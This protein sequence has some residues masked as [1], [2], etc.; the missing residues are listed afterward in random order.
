MAT[1]EANSVVIVDVDGVVSPVHGHTAWGDD[2]KAGDVLGP[3]YVSPSMCAQLE[4]L[5]SRPGVSGWWLTSWSAEMRGAMQLF[6]GRMWPEVAT[7]PA[8][9]PRG[10]WKW[11]ALTA[12]LDENPWI[13]NLVWCDDHLRAAERRAGI[14]RQLKERGLGTLLLAPDT[15]VGLTPEHLAQMAGFLTT[16]DRSGA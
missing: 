13:E 4:A 6:P 7:Q 16:R 10:W 2:Q 15:S 12:W 1:G 14:R 3:V 9:V 8:V 5:T 11:R